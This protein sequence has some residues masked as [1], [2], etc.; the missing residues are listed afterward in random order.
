MTSKKFK[1]IALDI[2][3]TLITNHYTISSR[4]RR[5]LKSAM[6]AGIKVTIATGRF[7]PSAYHIARSIAINA[8]MV[9]NDGALIKDVFSKRTLSF[10]P[11]SLNLAR[12][13]LDRA[14]RYR[15][16]KVQIFMLDYKIYAGHNYRRMQI[17]R[18]F[19]LSNRYTLIGCFNYLRDFVFVPVKNAGDIKGAMK[20]MQT[21]PAKLVIYGE[22][23]EMAAFKKEI[24]AYNVDKKRIFLTTAIKNTVDIL[25][26]EISKA[27]GL[28]ILAQILG[29][30]REEIIAVGDNIN[31]M[32]MLEYAGLGVAM[33]NAPDIV[34]QKADVVTASNNE[35][36]IAVLLEGLLKDNL[37]QEK[38][39]IVPQKG[40]SRNERWM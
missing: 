33:G 25:N 16:F 20:L 24:A 37:K 1:L 5:A 4:T 34:K 39:I 27:R 28:A 26:G 22:P 35:D 30:K 8:P 23:E 17:Q 14:S 2:D 9:C 19:K 10:T 32:G 6:D 7:Y 12:E 11:L 38:K 40:L 13:L 31:D 36:G 15:S 3:G 21:P 29:I 18:F